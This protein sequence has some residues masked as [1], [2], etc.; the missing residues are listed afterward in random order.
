M[1]IA[2]SFVTYC[3]VLRE[4]RARELEQA[5]AEVERAVQVEREMAQVREFF[6]QILARFTKTKSPTA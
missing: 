1:P 3:F 4:E 5:A 2:F 6:V